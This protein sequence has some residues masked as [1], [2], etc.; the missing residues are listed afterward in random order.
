MFQEVT[1][2]YSQ[3]VRPPIGSMFLKKLSVFGQWL[4]FDPFLKMRRS[5]SILEA[6]FI[7]FGA[8]LV[9]LII[10][11]RK[12]VV[13]L[14]DRLDETKI[15]VIPNYLKKKILFLRL[16]LREVNWLTTRRDFLDFKNL[17]NLLTHFASFGALEKLFKIIWEDHNVCLVKLIVMVYWKYSESYN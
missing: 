5:F 9:H 7:N 15:L 14:D 1:M 17:E 12:N 2:S 3:S 6:Y 16:Y 11:V 4:Y 13:H 10:I 8:K